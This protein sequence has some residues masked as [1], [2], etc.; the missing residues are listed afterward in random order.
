LQAHTCKVGDHDD[1]LFSISG[2]NIL[3]G[4]TGRCLEIAGGET[5]LPGSAILARE[6]TDG[7]SQAFTIE[8]DGRI[9]TKGAELCLAVGDSSAETPGPSHVRRVLTVERCDAVRA[10]LITWQVGL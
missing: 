1:Q 4:T 5:P 8:E 2:A 9:S 10:E 6:C 7:L 3:V